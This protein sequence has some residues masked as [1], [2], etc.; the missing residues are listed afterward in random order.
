M[1]T[2]F[3]FFL[4]TPLCL[5]AVEPI[6]E[7][8]NGDLLQGKLSHITDQHII[9]K[10]SLLNKETPFFLE[11]ARDITFPQNAAP[12]QKSDHIARIRFN[13]DLRQQNENI[14]ADIIEGELVAVNDKDIIL[15][16]WYAGQLKLNRNMV[17]DLEI[18]DVAPALYV[19]PY[20]KD[21]WKSLPK[22]SWRFD[23]NSY[24]S[25]GSGAIAKKFDKMPERYCLRFTAAWK[26]RFSLQILFGAD[27]IE[28][29][30]PENYYM[31]VLDNGTS[32][33][34]KRSTNRNN[35]GLM[36][37]GGMIGEYKRDQAFRNKEKAEIRLYVDTTTGLMALYADDTPVQEWQEIDLPMLNGPC[38]LLRQSSGRSYA[39]NVSRISLNTWDG[40]LPGQEDG[41]TGNAIDNPEPAEG[42]QRIIL[43]NGDSLLG[44]VERIENSQIHLKTRFNEIKIPVSR[45]K[46]LALAPAEY[47]ERLLQ[48][49]DVR[50]W[51]ANGNYI[52]FRLDGI[53]EDGKIRGTS[54][55]FGTAEFDATAFTRIEFNLYP[56]S[57]KK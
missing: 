8:T 28:E 48:N 54:Q 5:T 45:V 52:T 33:L 1:K 19:G 51:F 41:K 30:T 13:Q 22:D 2:L 47:D 42:E 36:R 6:L 53:K 29:E 20:E 46:K 23:K 27:S 32:Y 11:Q 3:H 57:V 44:K 50:A 9:W 56:A 35:I 14:S 7:F 16:T 24:T 21:E 40:N 39:I 34:Q 10:S 26:S 37:N 38:I 25:D 55:H 17:K 18:T 4:L 12:E 43:R 49:G 31:I 15:N